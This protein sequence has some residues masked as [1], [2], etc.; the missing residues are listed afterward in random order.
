MCEIDRIQG[1]PRRTHCLGSM[2][3][4]S[5]RAFR[6]LRMV[7]RSSHLLLLRIDSLHRSIAFG[8][9]NLIVS[10]LYLPMPHNTYCLSIVRMSKRRRSC[11]QR[12]EG[13]PTTRTRAYT[14]SSF[15]AHASF[16]DSRHHFGLS[17]LLEHPPSR[18]Y[19]VL[20]N[21]IIYINPITIRR[22]CNHIPIVP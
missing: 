3:A 16:L 6:G 14:S 8:D 1:R 21:Q 2:N 5:G 17:I 10:R 7:R 20:F 15:H 4:S 11:W 12:I 9:L 22:S 19:I 18:L 13:P